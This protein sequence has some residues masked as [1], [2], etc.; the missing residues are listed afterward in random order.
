MKAAVLYGP[1]D[2]RYVDVETPQPGPGEVLVRVRYAGVCG[3][4]VHRVMGGSAYHYPLVPGHEFAG[5][6]VGAGETPRRVTV[7]PLIPCRQC[8][9]CETGKY[10]LCDNYSYLGSRR[11]GGFAE[12]VVAP[13]ENLIPLP[14]DVSYEEGATIEAAGG[15]LHAIRR[16]GVKPGNSV[17]IFGAGPIGLCALQ[18]ARLSGA[19]QVIVVDPVRSKLDLAKSLG[20]TAVVDPTVTAASEAIQELTGGGVDVAVDFSGTPAGQREAVASLRKKGTAV[21]YGIS[22]QGLDLSPRLVDRI[23]RHELTLR[24]AWNA[25]FSRTRAN[26]WR[27]ALQFIASGRLATRPLITHRFPL[28][29]VTE[30]FKQL[31]SPQRDMVKVVFEIG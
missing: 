2:I 15:A 23:L 20:A 12:Y 14:E 11:D 22:H 19:E 10:N 17:A 31:A 7:I 25:D 3:S 30:V 29:A 8:E 28:S 21:F 18:W 27:V 16:A 9:F 5:E 26:D 6:V 4:D 13:I 24:G 1:G